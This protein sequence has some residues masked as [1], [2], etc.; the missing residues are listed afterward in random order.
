MVFQTPTAKERQLTALERAK[1]KVGLGNAAWFAVKFPAAGAVFPFVAMLL[2]N[3]AG[4]KS[5]GASADPCDFNSAE[6]YWIP[7]TASFIAT[8]F[9]AGLAT[10]FYG[11]VA[12]PLRKNTEGNNF[13]PRSLSEEQKKEF[14]MVLVPNA[15]QLGLLFAK[16][17]MAGTIAFSVFGLSAQGV[18]CISEKNP[19]LPNPALA[20]MDVAVSSITAI[21]FTLLANLTK[22]KI[23]PTQVLQIFVALIT[24]LET[25]NLA[26]NL[27][28]H[29]GIDNPQVTA[30]LGDVIKFAFAGVAGA[31][32][33]LFTNIPPI[34]RAIES[35][36]SECGIGDKNFFCCGPRQDGYQ[37]ITDYDGTE[38]IDTSNPRYSTVVVSPSMRE[39]PADLVVHEQS[40]TNSL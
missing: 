23:P 5:S 14:G 19:S 9:Y 24:A 1:T 17:L 26:A 27:A 18:A 15:K 12:K 4:N 30:A 39:A 6:T 28:S 36:L 37:I 7:I 21:V 11:L 3:V 29:M 2:K 32:A 10:L 31:A 40:N 35:P 8:I 22:L 38:N 20:G 33:G 13:V 25:G 16:T 34:R